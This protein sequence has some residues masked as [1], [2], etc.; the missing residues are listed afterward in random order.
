[1]RRVVSRYGEFLEAAESV[2]ERLANRY[3][4]PVVAREF[5]NALDG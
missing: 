2:S 3:A 4:E 5:M 1:M